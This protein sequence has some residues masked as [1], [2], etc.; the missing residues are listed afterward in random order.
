VAAVASPIYLWGRHPIVSRNAFGGLILRRDV[1]NLDEP[2]SIHPYELI[3]FTSGSSHAGR[4]VV[5]PPV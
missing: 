4:H 1:T 3:H 2:L 5:A